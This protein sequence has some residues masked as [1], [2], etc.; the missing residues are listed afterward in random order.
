MWNMKNNSYVNLE[1]EVENFIM[2]SYEDLL[3]NM[4]S[5]MLSIIERFD[6]P[7]PPII[8]NINSLITN[9]HGIRSQKFHRDFYLE[10]KWKKSIMPHHAKIINDSIDRELMEKFNYSYL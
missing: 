4:K 2:V 6:L 1:N 9:T 3:N 5:T 8:K 7:V 10:E